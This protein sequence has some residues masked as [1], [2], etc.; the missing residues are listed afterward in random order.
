M[1]ISDDPGL[2]WRADRHVPGELADS[3]FQRIDSG[4]ITAASLTRAAL[5]TDVCGVL[6]TSRDHYGRFSSLGDRLRVHGFL[7]EHF[8]DQI[9]LYARPGCDPS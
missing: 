2:V 8:G 7:A 9:T 5:A 6:V 3:S 1:V 4:D